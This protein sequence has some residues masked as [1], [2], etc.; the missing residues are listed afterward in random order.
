V[1]DEPMVLDAGGIADFVTAPARV[2]QGVW[3]RG[4]TALDADPWAAALV[5]QHA[6][7]VYSRFESDPEWTSFFRDMRALGEHHRARAGL[8]AET[9]SRDYDFVRLGDLMSLAFCS[10]WTDRH[11]HARCAL[12]GD[13]THYRIEPDPFGGERVPIEIR[14][15]RLPNRPY[16]D[17]ADAA[18]AWEIAERVTIAGSV[19]GSSRMEAQG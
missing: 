4:V 7:F 11:E 10:A 1:D 15:R 19:A 9:L 6:V 2:R 12:S 13:G 17:S 8:D 5:A 16:R 14:A 3:P 18:A